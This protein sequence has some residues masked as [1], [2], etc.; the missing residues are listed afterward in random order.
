M[1]R[2]VVGHRLRDLH[3]AIAWD[4]GLSLWVE[5]MSVEASRDWV[6]TLGICWV[7]RT[8]QLSERIWNSAWGTSNH[9]SLLLILALIGRLL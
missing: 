7:C 3:S 5:S 8:W 6:L 2:A 1:R 9:W 4:E